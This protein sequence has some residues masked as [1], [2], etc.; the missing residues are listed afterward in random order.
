LPAD[1]FSTRPG[2][3]FDRTG[4]ACGNV[5]SSASIDPERGLLFIASSNCDTDDFP[6][7]VPP[8]PPMPPY[9][10]AL[11]A[12][13]LDGDAAWVW[14]PDE[15]DNADLSFGGVPNLFQINIGGAM[16]DVVGIGNKNGT[17][18]AIDRDGVNEINGVTAQDPPESRNPMLPY[19]QTKVVQGGAIGGIIVSAAVVPPERK[20]FFSTAPGDT[21]LEIFDPQRPT[22]HALNLE[23]GTIAWEKGKPEDKEDVFP[24]FAPT[25]AVPGVVFM[26]TLVVATINVFDSEDGTLL[27][28]LDSTAQPTGV[29]S[30]PAVA[31]GMLFVGGGSGELGRPRDCA[32]DPFSAYCTALID[33]P[34]SAF[35]V[36]GTLGCEEAPACNDGNPC[37]YDFRE[38]GECRSENAADGLDCGANRGHCS[39]GQ[40]VVQPA[41]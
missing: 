1:F 15:V 31:G 21:E 22:A 40:C 18:Y 19:W 36:R 34:L 6:E 16:R 13:R 25:G 7:T 28:Q 5:W 39:A 29:A 12:L 24:S 10:R 4:T 14:R 17:Y 8:P 11:F 9:D 37:T 26:G 27:N 3:D 23:D 38:G 35:C 41:S 30:V 20:V 2:C 32:A 33:T